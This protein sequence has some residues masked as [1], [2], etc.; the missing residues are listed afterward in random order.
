M[1][2]V[3]IFYFFLERRI[4]YFMG[5]LPQKKKPKK[6]KYQNEKFDKMDLHGQEEEEKES[7]ETK[8]VNFVTKIILK[9]KKKTHT[10]LNE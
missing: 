5:T 7:G 3:S 8:S 9:K 10:I 2:V 4:G 6:K 1:I